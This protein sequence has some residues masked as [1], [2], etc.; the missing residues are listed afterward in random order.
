MVRGAMNVK[1]V[2]VLVVGFVVIA[3][4]CGGGSKK[5]ASSTTT[6]TAATTAAAATTTA[7]A[8]KAQSAKTSAPSFAS[9][10]NCVQLAALGA[11]VAKSLQPTAGNLQAT[12]ANETRALQ[13]M[14]SAAPSQIRGDFQTFATAFSA[15]AQ[16]ISKSGY[17]LGAVP[18][19]AQ[20]AQL[21]TAAKT[22]SAPKLRAAEQHLSAWARTNC[23]KG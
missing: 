10:H 5:S 3:G 20:V 22:F 1:L 14:A 15:Y 23:T 7:G 13:A 21:E 17:K 8:T 2:S 6:S 4:G 11:Q 18:T 9:V 19:A 16:A 12:V